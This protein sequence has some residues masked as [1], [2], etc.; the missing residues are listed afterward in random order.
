MLG[1]MGHTTRNGKT[2]TTTL[3]TTTVAGF[4]GEVIVTEGGHVAGCGKIY[5][6]F[7]S[8]EDAR[9]TNA[10][11]LALGT[12]GPE[13]LTEQQRIDATANSEAL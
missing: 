6:V 12:V 2:M 5:G 10:D 7:A 9:S 3:K 4:G 13:A 11:A 8:E 1:H